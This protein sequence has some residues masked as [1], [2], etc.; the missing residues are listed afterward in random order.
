MI[1]RRNILAA[2]VSLAAAPWPALRRKNVQPNVV[3][4][5]W[6]TLDWDGDTNASDWTVRYRVNGGVWIKKIYKQCD[7]MLPRF[8]V[9]ETL[10]L[11]EDFPY[12]MRF[13][14]DWSSGQGDRF[15]SVYGEDYSQKIERHFS[16]Q[17]HAFETE[18]EFAK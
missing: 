7:R 16:N 1:G 14:E 13:I 12:R 6:I 8:W 11:F 3:D 4:I 17:D 15:G 18:A 2:I 10:L 9:T 5:D